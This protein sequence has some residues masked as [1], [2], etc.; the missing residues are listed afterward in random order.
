MT[1]TK[2]DSETKYHRIFPAVTYWTGFIT[3]HVY[4]M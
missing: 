3:S 1:F 2:S 4:G